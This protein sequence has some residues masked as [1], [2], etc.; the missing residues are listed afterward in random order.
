MLY[1]GN[2][3]AKGCEKLTDEQSVKVTVYSKDRN[4]KPD[5][6]NANE[7]AGYAD[8]KSAVCFSKTI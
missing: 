4:A 7:Q 2:T 6:E 1:Q 8:K 5:S 3:A